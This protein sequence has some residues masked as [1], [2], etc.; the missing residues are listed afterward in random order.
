MPRLYIEHAKYMKK[1][2]ISNLLKELTKSDSAFTA[3]YWL[4]IDHVGTVSLFNLYAF[5]INFI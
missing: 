5:G 1:A 3:L 2:I 4:S